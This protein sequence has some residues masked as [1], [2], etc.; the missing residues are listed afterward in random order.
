MPTNNAKRTAGFIKMAHPTPVGNT[1]FIPTWML[2]LPAKVAIIREPDACNRR[3]TKVVFWHPRN[4]DLRTPECTRG[5]NVDALEATNDLDSGNN[6]FGR[7]DAGITVRA[8]RRSQD[9]DINPQAQHADSRAAA[10]S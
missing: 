2:L 3:Q 6:N 8:G 1:N 9:F 10:Q 5:Q 4:A 7:R